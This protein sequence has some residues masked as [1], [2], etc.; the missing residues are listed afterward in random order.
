VVA[1]FI[2]GSEINEQS[3]RLPSK[4]ASYQVSIHWQSSFREDFSEINQS[5]TRIAFGGH[6]C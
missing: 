4:D 1:I 3:Y 2:N 6:V 5:K